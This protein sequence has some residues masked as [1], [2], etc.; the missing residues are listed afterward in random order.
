MTGH[1]RVETA[2]SSDAAVARQVADAQPRRRVLLTG[3]ISATD[4]TAL[5]SGCA[6]RCVLCD[7][8]GEID[9][10]FLGRS[11]V[12]GL[13]VGARCEIAGT[14]R[15]DGGRFVVWNPLYRLMPPEGRVTSEGCRR[16]RLPSEDDDVNLDEVSSSR[17]ASCAG[18]GRSA[19]PA[20]T[21][22]GTNH[23][24]LRLYLG[25]AA[26]VGKTIAML[27]E[28]RRLR[29]LGTDVVVGCV[30]SH[31]RAETA[32]RMA[33]LEVVPRRLVERRGAGFEELDLE[34]IIARRPVVALVDEL[35]HTNVPEQG[36]HEKRW[37]DVLD[38]LEAGIDVVS[39]VNIQH[40]ESLADGIELLTGVRV[41]ERVPDWVVRRADR[42]ELVDTSPEQLRHRM[43]N[44]GVYPPEEAPQALSAFFRVG[45]LTALRE[46]AQR[47]LSRAPEEEL[48]GF[49]QRQVGARS[50]ETGEQVMV[51]VG[52]P[53]T[54]AIVR[55]A[56]RLAAAVKAE[57]H[58]VHVV[59]PS[60]VGR[61]RR[62]DLA[63]L[64]GL[65][66]AVGA[67]WH[68]VRSDD[69]AS[70]LVGFARQQEITQIMLGSSQRG[71]WQEITG[72]GSTV[73]RVTILANSTDLDV[74]II[75]RRELPVE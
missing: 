35:A 69:I 66:S 9:L 5:G 52:G 13:E 20:A 32:A 30:E 24:R 33:N 51:G 74:H 6:Y 50:G 16:D 67:S 36:R 56:W 28:A 48:L 19:A 25:A 4:M 2:G 58:A 17:T 44:G 10:L 34:A 72:G 55:R 21:D 62:E 63:Q 12:A 40:L 14:A 59:N 53:G 18:G 68:E 31:G 43:L 45:N 61:S 29:E 75:A 70:A 37:Q 23:G 73:R 39:T 65:V 26:G 22:R 8:T 41:S 38:L 54:E 15:C 71:R 60:A 11:R 1:S 42:I 64:R 7:A 47:F 49:L 3:Q 27:E 46:L 57:L